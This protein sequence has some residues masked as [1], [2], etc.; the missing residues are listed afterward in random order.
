MSYLIP[1][2]QLYN[3]LHAPIGTRMPFNQSTSPLG[4]V[5][6]GN[7]L[8]TDC[9]SRVNQSTA[10]GHGGS[11][12]WSGF[13]FGA[14]ISFNAFTISTAQMPTHTHSVSDGGHAMNAGGNSNITQLNFSST[15]NL[16]VASF[17]GWTFDG[18]PDSTSTNG[19]NASVAN[20][21]GGASVTPTFTT[22]QIKYTDHIIGV[23]Q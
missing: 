6:D 13:Y 21:G 17:G 16:A 12:S 8:Y 19:A 23:K 22:P 15:G 7:S 9:A 18:G 20:A 1:E 11:T 3:Q 4:W 14:T 10:G 5:T 2:S